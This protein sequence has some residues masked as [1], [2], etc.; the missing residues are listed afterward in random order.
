MAARL[1]VSWESWIWCALSRCGGLVVRPERVVVGP[2]EGGVPEEEEDFRLFQAE[3]GVV[4]GRGGVC[5]LL[6]TGILLWL[7]SLGVGVRVGGSAETGG[8]PG[9]A[10]S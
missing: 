7:S 8:V 1:R 3:N 6:Q 2:G 5:P 4:E 9:C 10:E